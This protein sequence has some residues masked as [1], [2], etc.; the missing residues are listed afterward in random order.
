MG[1]QE[2]HASLG[3]HLSSAIFF[4]SSQGSH[5]SKTARLLGALYSLR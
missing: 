5:L 4:H 3:W 2:D 1:V